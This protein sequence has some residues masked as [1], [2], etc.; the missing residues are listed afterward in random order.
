MD[1]VYG[2]AEAGVV[3]HPRWAIIGWIAAG[4]FFT[5][6]AVTVM[7]G[8]TELYIRSEIAKGIAGAPRGKSPSENDQTRP[9]KPLA[10]ESLKLQ[11]DQTRILLEELPKLQ[12]YF[13]NITIAYTASDTQGLEAA[14]QYM[15][16]FERSGIHP[17][18]ITFTPSGPEDEGVLIQVK[19]KNYIPA[20][21]AK[22]RE[23]FE[24]A[25]VRTVV[26]DGIPHNF[27]QNNN[28]FILFIAPARFN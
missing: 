28:D 13:K 14:E 11:P 12:Q 22:L 21:A 25:G 2:G 15:R 16:L 23:V 26:H 8:A 5:I 7:W 3:R 1:S 20:G 10:F 18:Q 9:Q 6:I 17:T 24:I 19:D 27:I 4:V